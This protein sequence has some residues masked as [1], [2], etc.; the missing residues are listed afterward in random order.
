MLSF[1]VAGMIY[2]ALPSGGLCAPIPAHNA[3]KL[4]SYWKLQ[5][6]SG[7][8]SPGGVATPPPRTGHTAVIHGGAGVVL[9]EPGVVRV[10]PV[11][12]SNA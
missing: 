2:L 11:L 6:E 5:L 4:E 10:E 8:W 9:V 1:D 12:A 3:Y 7:E